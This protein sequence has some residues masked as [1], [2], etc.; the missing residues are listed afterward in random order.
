VVQLWLNFILEKYKDLSL[1]NLIK[2]A[3]IKF[4]NYIDPIQLGAQYMK[5]IELKDFPK[6]LIKIK[7]KTWQNFFLNEAKKLSSKIIK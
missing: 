2:D 4:D 6:M 5:A 3:Q 7:E 1:N